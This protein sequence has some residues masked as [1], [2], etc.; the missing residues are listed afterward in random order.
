MTFHC[1]SRLY[2]YLSK[3]LEY[4]IRP[5]L[6]FSSSQPLPLEIIQLCLEGVNEIVATKFSLIPHD[7]L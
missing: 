4:I 1:P 6:I 3:Y 7:L 5:I 2:P